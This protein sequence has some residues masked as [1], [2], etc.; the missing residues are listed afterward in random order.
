M[1]QLEPGWLLKGIFGNDSLISNQTEITDSKGSTE[2]PGFQFLDYVD[3]KT[4]INQKRRNLATQARVIENCLASFMIEVKV[5]EVETG[6]SITRFALEPGIGIAVKKVTRHEDD[7]ALALAVPSVT[8]EAPIPGVSRIGLQVPNKQASTVRLRQLFESSE[9]YEKEAILKMAL[10]LNVSGHSI[11]ADLTKMPHLLIAGST[12]AGKSVCLNSIIVTLLAQHGPENLQ[13]IMIDPKMVELT[14][15]QGLPHLKFPVVTQIMELDDPDNSREEREKPTARKVLTWAVNEMEKRYKILAN[16]GNRNIESYNKSGK[17]KLSYI[18]IIIDELADLMMTAPEEIETQIC[19]LAQKARAVGIH[20]I[21]ATQRPSVDVITGLIKANF[22]TRIAFAVSSQVDSR[23]ILDQVG[24]EKLLGRGDMLYVPPDA[25]KP[26]RVQGVYVSDEE[27]DK[28][29]QYWKGYKP[30]PVV[31][32]LPSPTIQLPEQ[33][34]ELDSII[35]LPT[36][37]NELPVLTPRSLEQQDELFQKALEVVRKE[38]LASTS[39]LQRK[40]SVGYNR[41]A[42]L[43]EALANAGHI[44]LPDKLNN[45]TR[46]VLNQE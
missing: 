17:N 45:M 16:A 35:E 5:T 20:L 10:G 8:F 15:Y 43:I 34:I 46:P 41:A 32:S 7:L 13:F 25:S 40:L 30:V 12:G 38:G 4:D 29:I 33:I 3:T 31:L 1:K 44:G 9:F 26:I 39:L 36:D 28:L 21:V 23:V 42:K 37:N 14:P 2:P 6:P 22:P 18:V 11:T 27:I 24:A 19:R